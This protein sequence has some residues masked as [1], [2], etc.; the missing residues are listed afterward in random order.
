MPLTTPLDELLMTLWEVLN[1]VFDWVSDVATTI[2]ST[3]ILLITTGFL[4]VGGAIAIFG[5]LLSKR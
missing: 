4:V 1:S 5:R 3:P 2:V